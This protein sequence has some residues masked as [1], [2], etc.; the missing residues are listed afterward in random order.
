[1]WL[2]GRFRTLAYLICRFSSGV[3][4]QK[5]A[6]ALFRER[7]KKI[8]VR[9]S[10]PAGLFTPPAAAP[11]RVILQRS[12]T[13]EAAQH[14]GALLALLNSRLHKEAPPAHASLSLPKTRK[15]LAGFGQ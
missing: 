10:P 9:T 6:L 7:Q 13:T 5:R 14:H 8:W 11:L 12:A 1:M 4:Q 2:E 15:A 3:S